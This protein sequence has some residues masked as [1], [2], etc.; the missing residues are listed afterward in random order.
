MDVQ[1]MRTWDKL[2][3]PSDSYLYNG[4]NSS[5]CFIRLLGRLNEIIYINSLQQSGVYATI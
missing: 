5:I 3:S 4:D 1:S 2:L